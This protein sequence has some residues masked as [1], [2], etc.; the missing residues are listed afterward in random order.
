MLKTN[1]DSLRESQLDTEQ[2]YDGV[3][4]KVH[5]DKV[6]LPDGKTSAREYIRHPGA[7][8]VIAVLPDRRIIFERQFRY[9]LNRSFIELPAGKIDPGESAETCAKRELQEEVGYTAAQ[10]R[11]IGALHP[12]VGY[13]DEQIEVFLARDLTYVGHQW[14]DGEFLEVLSLSYQEARAAVRAGELTD[15]KT[16]SAL[17]IAENLLSASEENTEAD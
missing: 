3:M 16:L 12:C 4:L 7:V 11:R 13:S 14:D 15:G 2:V 17:F 10:W 5:R 8:V 6:R 9:P 1:E